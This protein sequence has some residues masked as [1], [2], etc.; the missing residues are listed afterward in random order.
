MG[1]GCWVS[2]T[3]AVTQPAS[4]LSVS[5]S[6]TNATGCATLGTISASG[7]GGTAP[8][9][10]SINGEAKQSS[11]IF[12]GLYAGN[13]LVA[14]EDVNGCLATRTVSITDNG[15]DIYEPN[16][17]KK[18]AKVIQ[19]GSTVQARM[20]IATD[21]ADWFQFT[22]P[23]G[24]APSYRVSLSHPSASFAFDVYPAGNNTTALMPAASG[25]GT[26]DYMLNGGTTYFII[27]TGGLSFV[28]YELLVESISSPALFTSA[29]GHQSKT[30]AD[31][32]QSLTATAFPNPHRG[33][34]TLRIESPV[35]GE[36]KVTIHD[37]TGRALTERKVLL[38]KGTNVVR[39]D[40]VKPVSIVYRVVLD[41]KWLSGKLIGIK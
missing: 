29:P 40:G 30:I 25:A 19:V 14:I 31:E 28:C 2:Q 11:G 15:G 27:V 23:A 35:S 4:N 20:A 39:F 7:S 9:M 24:S 13:Y 32:G 36:G 10:F 38:K 34:F 41:G 17:G 26:R 18:Q 22:T 37:F 21:A 6:L 8:Y 12:T 16:N 1:S 3:Y 33:S 5:A